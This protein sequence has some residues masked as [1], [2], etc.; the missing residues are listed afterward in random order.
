VKK[1]NKYVIPTVV[2]S[3]AFYVALSFYGDWEKIVALFRSFELSVVPLLLLLSLANYFTRFLKWHYYLRTVTKDVS[4]GES[5]LVFHSALALSFSPGKVGDLIKSLFLK[6]SHNL[7]ISKTAS[8][9]LVERITDFTSLLLISVAGA[10]AYNYGRDAVLTVSLFFLI[11]IVLLSVPSLG[12]KI[13]SIFGKVEFLKKALAP[14]ETAYETSNQL[15]APSRLI[16]MTLLS[17]LAWFFECLGFY[18]ILI[19]FKVQI[20][21]FGASFIYAFST[22]IGAVTMAPAGIGFTEGSL[23]FLLMEYGSPKDAAVAATLLVRLV[24]LWFAVVVGLANLFA[25]KF[26]KKKKN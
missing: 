17:L 21:L 5:F 16:T 9:V 8:I 7:E 22:I 2:F 24:T 4:F 3:A 1:Y 10:F 6:E 14:F 25:Y 19:N 23:T 11:L 15:L 12:K 13:I 18:I 20:S 26:Y